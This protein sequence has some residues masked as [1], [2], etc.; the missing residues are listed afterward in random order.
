MAH[1]SKYLTN[2]SLRRKLEFAV[3]CEQTGETEHA[4]ELFAEILLSAPHEELKSTF[5]NPEGD[6]VFCMAYQG[7]LRSASSSDECTW[8]VASQMLGDLRILAEE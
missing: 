7:L 8:E 6:T 5:E 2:E 3:H 4:A 1:N